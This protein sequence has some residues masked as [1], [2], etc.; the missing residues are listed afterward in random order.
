MAL[1]DVSKMITVFQKQCRFAEWFT[2]VFREPMTQALTEVFARDL[3]EGQEAPEVLGIVDSLVRGLVSTFKKLS[4]AEMKLLA[5]LKKEELLRK[6]EVRLTNALK[7][8]FDRAR[9]ICRS[10]FGPEKADEAGFPARLA[11]EALPLLRQT[12]VVSFN[13]RE[14]EFDLGENLVPG[15][16]HDVQ[17]ILETYEPAARELQKVLDDGSQQKAVTQGM[18]VE[19]NDAM[20]SFRTTYGIYVAV[21]RGC[22]RLAGFTELADRLT[23]TVRRRSN[24]A[25]EPDPSPGDEPPDTGPLD[26]G[27]S[28]G[29]PPDGNPPVGG[30]SDDVPEVPPEFADFVRP[31]TETKSDDDEK[32]P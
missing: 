1:Q 24:G 30:D 25:T 28:D 9:S 4:G 18:Q 11:P 13:L 29:G 26:G 8:A 7:Q 14:P 31:E 32:V 22:F 17:T 20:A 10:N 3:P 19:K 16:N 27:P 5:S 15:S 6:L 2:R 21:V 23:L 12:D